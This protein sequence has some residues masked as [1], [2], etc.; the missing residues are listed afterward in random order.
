MSLSILMS[1]TAQPKTHLVEELIEQLDV[2]EHGRS[3]C[4][5]IRDN[6]EECFRT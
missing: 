4:E 2:D 3:V 6:V 5:L 1:K